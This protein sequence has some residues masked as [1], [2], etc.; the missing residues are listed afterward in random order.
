MRRHLRCMSAVVRRPTD[1]VAQQCSA[2]RPVHEPAEEE[3]RSSAL[4]L[5]ES[6]S[7]SIENPEMLVLSP[8]AH[9]QS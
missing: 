7:H 3:V 2:V 9:P 5:G 6:T 4:A 8:I 1:R